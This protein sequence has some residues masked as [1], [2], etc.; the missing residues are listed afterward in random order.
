ME[1]LVEVYSDLEAALNGLSFN[2]RRY[3]SVLAL[4]GDEIAARR[5]S[6]TDGKLVD[7]W[8]NDNIFKLREEA[9][10]RSEGEW[11]TEGFTLWLEDE[12]PSVMEELMGII[13]LE[14]D[15]GRKL[16][17]KERAVEFFLKDLCGLNRNIR[18]SVSIDKLI[19]GIMEQ[20]GK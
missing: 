11:R 13:H 17:V 20:E 19:L 12:L 7:K 2:Q 15:E 8:R 14:A 16:A 1:N 4:R 5:L 3:L 6:S 10:K 9:V 18:K